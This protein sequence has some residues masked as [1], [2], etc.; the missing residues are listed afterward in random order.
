[1]KNIYLCGFMGC[2]KST[3]GNELASITG[4]EFIDMDELIVQR[5][6]M[7]V[8]EIFERFG[9]AEFRRLESEAAKLLSLK[10]GMV[11]ATG[12]GAVI[13]GANAELFRRSGMI[14]LIDVP[15]EVILHRLEGDTTRPLLNAPERKKTFL[16]L[17]AKRMPVYRAAADFTVCNRNDVPAR[18]VAQELIKMLKNDTQFSTLLGNSDEFIK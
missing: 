8:P 1:M 4:M 11:V 12:G 2:G 15:P 3:V 17:Y 7:T 10:S 13:N 16:E 5:A 18:E 9:E 14:V 6:G